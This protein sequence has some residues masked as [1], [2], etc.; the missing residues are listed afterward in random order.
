[1]CKSIEDCAYALNVIGKPDINDWH[2][3]RPNVE[4]DY[5]QNLDLPLK[6]LKIAYSLNM[7][8]FV[9]K[10]HPDVIEAF[11]KSLEKFKKMGA[12]IHED[13]PDFGDISYFD[14]LNTVWETGCANSFHQLNI[15]VNDPYMDKGLIDNV[16]RGMKHTSV[17][18]MKAENDRFRMGVISEKFFKKYDALITP[19]LP[20]PAFQA[21]KVVPD[22]NIYGS[23]KGR[24]MVDVWQSWTPYTYWVNL[25]RQPASSV[26]MGYSKDG[27][28]LGLQVVGPL[29][30]EEMVLRVSHQYEINRDEKDHNIQ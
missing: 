11:R 20:L 5:L 24:D 4:K 15:D 9:D 17:D 8:G 3:L 2:S 29:Y 25:T 7:R 13:F 21:G 26:C 1:M 10:V 27:L 22:Q 12:Y 19:T 18:L 23:K 30:N 16:K 28:P 6:G 14:V